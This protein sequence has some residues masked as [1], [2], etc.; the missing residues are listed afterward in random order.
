MTGWLHDETE[1]HTSPPRRALSADNAS[2]YVAIVL[3]AGILMGLSVWG[4]AA[5][6]MWRAAWGW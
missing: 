3:G 1:A 4:A 2:T 6:A 5:L